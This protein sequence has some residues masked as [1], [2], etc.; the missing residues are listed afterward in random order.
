M[1]VDFSSPA[2]TEDDFMKA[3]EAVRA[4]GTC[5]FLATLITIRPEVYERNLRL[6]SR[7]IEREALDDLVPGFHIEGP[8][9][10]AGGGIGAHDP[11]AVMDPQTELVDNLMEWSSGR[12]M[13]LTMSAEAKDAAVVIRYCTDLGIR[14]S[15]GHSIYNQKL[16]A[17]AAD[18]G[19]ISLTHLGNALPPLLPR[20]DHPVFAG[21]NEDRLIAMMISDGHH[22]PEVLMRLILKVK[23]YD[24][25]II[26]SDAAPIAGLPPG[27]YETLGN[28]VVLEECGRI[29]NP[30]TER[31]VGSPSC[32]NDC[33]N[34]LADLGVPEDALV[35]MGYINPLRYLGINL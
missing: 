25:T 20:H 3:C 32:M 6:M 16:L 17:E 22:L 34:V 27:E 4:S 11:S 21:L 1:G 31:L 12:I 2:L 26:V 28:K 18:A 10:S 19:A 8:F 30:Q 5:R 9:I 24:R 33:M 23:G 29:W 7:V 14:V 15:I 35:R 13:M